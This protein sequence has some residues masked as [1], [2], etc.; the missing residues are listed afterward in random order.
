[1]GRPQTRALAVLR[2]L[3]ACPGGLTTTEIT[4]LA[5]PGSDPGR[6]R[7]ACYLV[8]RHLERQ[9]RACRTGTVKLRSGPAAVTWDRPAARSEKQRAV[10]QAIAL[11]SRRVTLPRRAIAALDRMEQGIGELEQ[12]E[13]EIA[14]FEAEHANPGGTARGGAVILTL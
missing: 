9:G 14:A 12:A 1:M 13:R 3:T 4:A 11:T 2:V 8:L 10:R 7:A 6:A 5:Y